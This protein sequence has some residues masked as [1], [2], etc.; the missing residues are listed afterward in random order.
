MTSERFVTIIIPVYNGVSV[1]GESV[2][3]VFSQD[4]PHVELIVVND[5]SS[6]GSVKLL[7][8]LLEKAPSNVTMKII[9]QP[10]GGICSARNAGLDAA[11][12]DLIAFMDQDDRIPRDYVSSLVNAMGSE[13]E[14]VIG[15]T[16]DHHVASGKRSR[17]DM[18]PGAKWSMYRNTAPWGRLYR[19]DIID[20]NGI[21]F[22]DH[23]ISEDFYFNFLYLSYCH[24][25]KVKVVPQ[26]GYMWTISKDSESHANMSKIEEDRD[27]TEML[28][29]LLADMKPVTR[30]SALENELFEYLIIKHI[31][32][33]LLFVRKGASRKAMK[34]IYAKCMSWLEEHFPDYKKNPMLKPGRP[35][36]ESRKIRFIVRAAMRLHRMHLLLPILKM[37]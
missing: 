17:R 25:G 16:V 30:E 26:S 33:Y 23:K 31:V 10:N 9:D 28:D 34:E 7:E 27:V 14:A 21:R 37:M 5:G 2:G 19:R 18:D 22:E 1:L 3:D 13:D 12:G 8:T 32:W 4:Y 20:A 11:T 15:G 29:K 36:G 24:K 6:D 35:A